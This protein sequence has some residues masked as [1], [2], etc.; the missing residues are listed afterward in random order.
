MSADGSYDLVVIGGGHAGCEAAAA[1]ARLGARTLL[2]TLR[3]DRIAE[4]SC[5]PA[6]GGLAKGQ[7]V[8]E[9][10]ALGGLMGLAAD[11][12]GI[13]FL[14]LNR[15]R[16]PAV[17]APRAQ[18]DK[19]MYR[20]EMLRLLEAMQPPG[21]EIIESE[22]RGI[23][24][25]GGRVEGV[26]TADGEYEAK[27]VVITSGTF[28]NALIHIGRKT[29]HAGRLG[30]PASKGLS[31]S[32]AK[33]GLELG[34]LK[35]GT[36]PRLDRSSIDFSRFTP[37]PGDDI[38]AP[39]SFLTSRI[40][41]EQVPC[42]IGYTNERTHALIRANI[43]ESPLYSGRIVGIGPRY[44][45]S[46]EDKVVKFPERDRHQLFLEPE[47]REGESIYINGIST[48]MPEEIQIE[49]IRTV[50][51]LE[52]AVFLR[53]GYAIEYDF[54]WPTQ[55]KATLECKRI[56]GLFLAG[57]INGTSGYE[58]AA[59]QGLVAGANAALRA[60]HG[61][62]YEPFVL[63]RQT[64]YI[65]VMIDD[66]ITRGVDEPYRMFTSRAENRLQLRADNADRRL[67]PIGERFG[68][69]DGVRRLAFREKQERMERAGEALRSIAVSSTAEAVSIG[70]VP[71]GEVHGG[72]KLE[73]LLRRPEVS[74]G[75]FAGG[76]EELRGLS[77][78]ELLTIETDIKY[79]GYV[80]RQE[81]MLERLAVHEGMAIPAELN[82]SAIPGLSREA[83]Q[84]LGRMRPETLGQASRVPGLT[85]AA[86]AALAIELE[87]LR[88]GVHGQ[89]R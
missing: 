68:L 78:E 13:Q 42:H 21:L 85:P 52:E 75:Q 22:A 23:V 55:L 89:R 63:G 81:G 67:T 82:Y 35:T 39:F 65:G 62:G 32:L 41:V 74:I 71:R 58:E 11:R 24:A 30:E 18:Q 43:G 48:S 33:L 50:E 5:N 53:P 36:P 54:V 56:K 87:R 60:L 12:C 27:T 40:E 15:S 16:G 2:V 9:V 80:R 59:G 38:P 88:R 72:T 69:I 28:L 84:R 79:E 29:F 6:I 4:M 77:E 49:M 46:I 8:R 76:V 73:E 70:M 51:G 26:R 83:A 47:E 3:R 86:V 64:S 17:R 34:R 25:R 44:C 66:L 14:L 19:G 7:I 20:R 10:D 37:Q 61:G 57:Q 1:A 45:P 31:E